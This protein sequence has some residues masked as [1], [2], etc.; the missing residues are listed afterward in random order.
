VSTANGQQADCLLNKREAANF[1]GVSP[2]TLER[3]VRRGDL[4][5]IKITD[6]PAG[7]V[8]FDINALNAF[9]EARRVKHSSGEVRREAVQ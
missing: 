8:R 4:S 3:I 9:I 5:F 2:G 1:L 6:G 7:A